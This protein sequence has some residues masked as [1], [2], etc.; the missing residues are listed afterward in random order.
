M[1]HIPVHHKQKAHVG[2]S[3]SEV[4]VPDVVGGVREAGQ[5]AALDLVL[6]LRTGLHPRQPRLDGRL[7]RLRAKV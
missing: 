5:V 4:G 7:Q 2:D 1:L 6:A 3:P